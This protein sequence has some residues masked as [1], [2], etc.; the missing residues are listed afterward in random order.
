MQSMLF[1]PSAYHRKADLAACFT[2]VTFPQSQWSQSLKNEPKNIVFGGECLEQLTSL[3]NHWVCLS[4]DFTCD[5]FWANVILVLYFFPILQVSSLVHYILHFFSFVI[6]FS[7]ILSF[8]LRHVRSGHL[9]QLPRARTSSA[10]LL[11]PSL[12]KHPHTGLA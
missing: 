4:K 8:L 3:R 12:Q 9:C 10:W 1:K 7:V 5:L 6:P 2:E 11:E